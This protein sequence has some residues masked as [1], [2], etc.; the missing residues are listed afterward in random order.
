TYD[1]DNK[2]IFQMKIKDFKRI[3]EQYQNNKI[4]LTDDQNQKSLTINNMLNIFNSYSS[5]SDYR[6]EKDFY[7]YLKSNNQN[8]DECKRLLMNVLVQVEYKLSEPTI[9]MILDQLE[10]MDYKSSR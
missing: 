10:K 4:L 6:I 8:E 9:G 2:N 1:T 3:I 5:I 7:K